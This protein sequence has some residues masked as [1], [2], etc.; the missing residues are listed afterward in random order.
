MADISIIARPY[1]KA[2]FELA[3]SEGKLGQWNDTLRSLAAA[4]SSPDVSGLLNH[5]ALTRSDLV[6]AL[7]KT[8]GGAEGHSLLRLL[9]ENGRL[10]AVPSMLSQYEALRAEAEARVDVEITSA[11]LV[12][13]PQQEALTTAI[14]KR[15]GR[16]VVVD[17]KTDES[18]IAGALIRAGDL[19][20]DGSVRGELEKLHTA[21][22]R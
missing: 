15:L 14:R 16:E 21:L 22:A 2:V 4:V 11:S 10:K 17:W 12:D 8:V 18:L 1:A 19:V 5:P 6:A 7:D 9:V 3:R 20:I 13:K